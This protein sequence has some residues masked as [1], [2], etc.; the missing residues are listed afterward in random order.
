MRQVRQDLTQH[1]AGKPSAVQRAMIERA[2]WLSLRLAQLDRKIADG[3]NFTQIDS[4]C[5][6][7]WNNSLVRTLARLGVEPKSATSRP[8]LQSILAEASA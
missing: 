2:V 3:K 7:A 1:V 8:S 5:Y 4:N 6:L